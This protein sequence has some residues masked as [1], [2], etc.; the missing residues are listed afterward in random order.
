MAKKQHVS[1]VEPPVFDP[2]KFAVAGNLPT[3]EVV[4]QT[5]S[6]VTGVKPVAK[7]AEPAPEKAFEKAFEQKIEKEAKPAAA[8]KKT[9]SSPSVK[10][11][12]KAEKP[13][14]TPSKPVAT[15][16]KV[17]MTPKKLVVERGRDARGELNRVGIT[18]LVDRELLQ[19]T[20]IWAVQNGVS[21][22][23]I[24]NDA[25]TVYLTKNAI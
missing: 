3:V 25:L 5:V 11:V 10:P 2:S 8:P 18:A 6:E 21:M 17:E 16:K 20:K 15:P 12:K 7:V 23:D 4:N 13:P 24:I 9:E 14:V 22:S 1:R 19:R